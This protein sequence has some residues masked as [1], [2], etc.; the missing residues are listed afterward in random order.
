MAEYPTPL[1]PGEGKK[2]EQVLDEM[3]MVVE[4]VRTAKAAHQ[5][6]EKYDVTLPISAA[7][8]SVLFEHKT[9]LDAVDDLMLRMKQREMDEIYNN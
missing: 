1:I 2:L 5:L 9:P 8:Y 6:A 4:G 7:L 3:G